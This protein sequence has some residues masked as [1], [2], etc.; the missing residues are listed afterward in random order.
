MATLP[1]P[2]VDYVC[3]DRV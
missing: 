2:E 3:G 1:C